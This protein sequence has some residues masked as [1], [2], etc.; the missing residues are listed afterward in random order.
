VP[1]AAKH[2]G[3]AETMRLNEEKRSACIEKFVHE[4]NYASEANAVAYLLRL[5]VS[6]HVVNSSW[7][8]DFRVLL[9]H[10]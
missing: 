2:L 8:A 1:V 4:C 7:I 3:K 10:Q 5:T 6:L 9:P